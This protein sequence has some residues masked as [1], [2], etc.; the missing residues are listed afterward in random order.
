MYSNVTGYLDHNKCS[1]WILIKTI[2]GNPVDNNKYN[3]SALLAFKG[4]KEEYQSNQ[5]LLH[6]YQH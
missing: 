5:N 2:I 1:T 4:Q 6:H 3:C